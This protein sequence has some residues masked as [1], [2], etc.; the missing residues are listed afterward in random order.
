VNRDLAHPTMTNQ[1]GPA[2]SNLCG[3]IALF[4]LVVGSLLAVL[5][6]DFTLVP[7]DAARP[8]N[9]GAAFARFWPL[10]VFLT[11]LFATSALWLRGGKRRVAPLTVGSVCLALF[12]LLAITPVGKS[13][14]LHAPPVT[15]LLLFV[16]LDAGAIYA[17]RR[18]AFMAR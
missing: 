8:L 2:V 11:W 14:L 15:V 1:R 16:A 7:P 17:A 5:L 9:T 13:V 3:G 6:V 10:V 12:P 4:I 18:F